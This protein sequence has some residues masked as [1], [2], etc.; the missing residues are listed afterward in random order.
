M[1]RVNE[2]ISENTVKTKVA[3]VYAVPAVHS[4]RIITLNLYEAQQM[5]NAGKTVFEKTVE[6]ETGFRHFYY[7]EVDFQS[8]IEIAE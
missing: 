1:A 6:S 3:R 4:R 5:L 8:L 7:I 2:L